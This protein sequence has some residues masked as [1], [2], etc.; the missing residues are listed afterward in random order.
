V[1]ATVIY[2]LVA[3]GDLPSIRIGKAGKTI[4]IPREEFLAWYRK[5]VTRSEEEKE[6]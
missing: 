4:R 3:L 5:G 1:S 6:V 2:D